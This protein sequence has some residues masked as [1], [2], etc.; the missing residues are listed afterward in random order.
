MHNSYF[1]QIVFISLFLLANWSTYSVAQSVNPS[2]PK[3]L[4]S[5]DVSRPADGARMLAPEAELKPAQ[6]EA[7]Q[8]IEQRIPGVKIQWN[9]LTGTP[10]RVQSNRS[11]LTDESVASSDEVM[12][13]FLRN[14]ADL[15]GLSESEI[16]NFEVTRKSDEPGA[17]RLAS[18]AQARLRHITLEQ[19]RLGRQIYP[20][21]LV[22]AVSSK[23]QLLS[24]AGQVTGGV[25]D[26]VKVS[27][28]EPKLTAVEAIGKVAEI[29][30]IGAGFDQDQHTL[31]KAPQ[32]PEKR[33]T[34]SSGKVFDSDI[35]MR[36]I[37]FMELKDKVSLVWAISA[38][39]RDDMFAYSIFIDAVNGKMLRRVTITSQDVPRWLVY[40]R[41]SEPPG[42]SLTTVPTTNAKND[43]APLDNPAPLSPGPETPDGSQG[44]MVKPIVIATNGDPSL[45]PNGFIQDGEMRTSGNNVVAFVDRNNN[46]L[47]EANEQPKAKIENIGG[48]ETRSFAFKADFT[49]APDSIANA[50]AATAQTF[51]VANWWHDRMAALGF[52]EAE[53]NFQ[54]KNKDGVGAGGDRIEARLHV[55]TNNST[56][57]TPEFDGRCC[58]TLNAYT[59]T[60]P[61]PDRDSGFDVEILIHEFTHGLTNRII[62]GPKKYGLTSQQGRGLGEGY[63]DLYALLLLRT[64]D[65]DPDASYTVGGYSTLQLSFTGQPAGWKDN[66]HFGIRHFPYTTDLCKNS[67]TLIDMQSATY[68]LTPIASAS[69]STT[70]PVSPWL[71]TKSGGFHDMG[72][73]WAA[74]VWEVR[75]NLV[76]KH[77]AESGNE[78][79][80]Q[81]LTDSLFQLQ[82]N[83]TF[84]DARDA[85]L[86]A[87][88]ARFNGENRC[89]IWRGFA[90]RGMGDKAATP[91]FGSFAEDFDVP[92][93]CA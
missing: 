53:G 69:C 5:F 46:G 76:R 74:T 84:V 33:Q 73:I 38:A 11:M 65:E 78:M 86:V 80:L 39:K 23:G 82:Q 17:A 62:G 8:K 34:W 75:R 89:E 85:I 15:Y 12:R 21:D 32:G 56:F 88:L 49:K 29:L 28:D 51:L 3:P 63:S 58:P 20:L 4:P 7:K 43:Y 81:L 40:F 66:Y 30:G 41:I 37:Y 68:D 14:N 42:T 27:T 45:S 55:G 35:P 52:T 79:T 87:D 13:S 60:G 25:G 72:E 67:F 19:R 59:W 90:K 64:P 47:P 16:S 1:G 31:L 93:D 54:L 91:E 36:L 26:K 48:V 44:M 2:Q 83:P 10:L 70:P 9:A 77:G 6:L 24:V 18:P 57:S 71:A 50:H 22:G 61:N 92:P